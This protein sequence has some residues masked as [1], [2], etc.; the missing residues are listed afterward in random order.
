MGTWTNSD[1]LHL[2]FGTDKS[3]SNYA[4]EYV[5]TGELREVSLRITLTDLADASAIMSDKVFFPKNARIEEVELVTHTAAT[6]GGAAVLNIGLVQA[7]DRSTAIDT[8]GFVAAL[9]LASFNSAGEKVVLRVGSTSAGALIGT[10]NSTVGYIVA[11][12][13][14]AAFTAGE[15][16]VR[17]RYR[18][19]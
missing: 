17:V 11:D 13:D 9:A 2:K 16:D 3:E 6:S 5:T 8:D 15:I 14:T 1:G 4:G 7:S 18:G 19:V 12:Y 10:T